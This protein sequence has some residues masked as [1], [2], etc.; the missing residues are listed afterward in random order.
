MRSLLLALL[1]F[2]LPSP[3]QEPTFNF[4]SPTAPGRITLPPR[5]GAW[6]PA[7]A[8]LY[9]EGTRPALVYHDGARD[10]NLSAILFP[11]ETGKPTGESCRDAL[12]PNLTAA[13]RQHGAVIDNESQ[14]SGKTANGAP[15]AEAHYTIEKQGTFAIHQR[16]VFAFAGDEHTCAEIHVSKVNAK[17]EDD[18]TID[19]I[20]S[21]FNMDLSYKPLPQD[22][23]TMG[24]LFFE[25]VKN[26]AASAVFYQR[27]FDSMAAEAHRTRMGRYVA[28]QLT[29]SY[30]MS[31]DLPRSGATA[32]AAI[33]LDPDYPLY[34]YNLACADAES[35]DASNAATHLQQAFDRRN[36][37]IAGETFPD[38]VKDDSLQKLKSNDTF[39]DLATTISAKLHR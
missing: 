29:M 33:A 37:L 27:A 17:V 22:Y 20:V 2:P 25:G 8:A 10:L 14:A 11:N 5:G 38:P 15:F 35:G 12:I 16:N 18:R 32:Q 3:A 6:K 30:G 39:W 21:T 23:E 19:D 26:Y 28:D 36:N 13:M 31:G 9:D 4:V 7:E 1:L 34:Y 24:V